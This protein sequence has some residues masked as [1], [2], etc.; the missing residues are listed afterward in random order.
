MKIKIYKK[1]MNYWIPGVNVIK[2]IYNTYNS[3]IR[4]GDI[5]VISEKALSVAYGNIYDEKLIKVSFIDKAITYLVSRFFW[6]KIFYKPFSSQL[7]NVLKNT[8]LKL[9]ARHKR[10]VCKIG[11]MK[12]LLKPI[13]ESGIDTTN[14]PYNYVSL[15][16][17][18]IDEIA[19][20]IYTS[21]IERFNKKI[22][23]LIMDTDKCFKLKYVNLVLGTR[24]SN[25]KGIIDL[26]G[27]AYFIGKYFRKYF[28]EYPTPVA[29]MG[30]D[31]SLTNLLKICRICEKQRGYG[32]GRNIIEM[33]RKLDVK[34][35][36]EIK[37]KDLDRV[38]HY[39]TFIVRIM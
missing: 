25:V 36:S 5:I 16:L 7:I 23:L 2:I 10:L 35:P 22:N 28:I 3:L 13:S 11:K 14:L 17:K 1:P 8:D 37:W 15:P 31:F 33:M 20:E 34:E 12:H 32:L 21:L 27:I 26:G 29:Y 4:N 19:K 18:N 24:P 6:G 38:R 39:P 9:L 30:Y